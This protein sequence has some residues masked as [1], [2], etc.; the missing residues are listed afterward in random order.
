[1]PIWLIAL[2]AYL[3]L[4]LPSAWLLIAALAAGTAPDASTNTSPTGPRASHGDPAGAVP[5]ARLQHDRRPEG[6]V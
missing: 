1:M 3:A 2:L 6:G 4:A 5:P